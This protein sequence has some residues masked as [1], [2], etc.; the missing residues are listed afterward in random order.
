MS[1]LILT[2]KR[3]I[4]GRRVAGDAEEGAAREA[5][6][7][8]HARDGADRRG[9]VRRERRDERPEP[10]KR[11]DREG[12]KAEER[13]ADEGAELALAKRRNLCILSLGLEAVRGNLV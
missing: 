10:G 11:R 2:R 12:E 5:G 13:Q 4:G 7:P 3:R 6:E 8:A 9:A 1:R